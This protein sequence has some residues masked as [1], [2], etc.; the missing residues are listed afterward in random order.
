MPKPRIT[1]AFVVEYLK[2]LYE[3]TGEIPKCKDKTHPFS[4]VTVHNRFGGWNNVLT[5][6]DIPLR[7]N[8]SIVVFCLT[9]N[10]EFKKDFNQVKKY[11]IHFCS[12]SCSA[13]YTNTHKTTGLRISKLERYIQDNII[14]KYE[15]EFNN[16]TI[17]DGLELDIYIPSIKLAFEING[18]LHY[19]PIYGTD[20]YNKIAER[21]QRKLLLCKNQDIKLVV[22]KDTSSRFSEEYGKE[23]LDYIT[24]F[25]Y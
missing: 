18:I 11:P 17:C 24:S 25:I 19:K 14:T 10:K 15:L 23:I 7:K 8:K 22:I 13:I 9:C 2:D 21:D 3:R 1:L 20:K 6:S 12:S 16:R 5:L 4:D